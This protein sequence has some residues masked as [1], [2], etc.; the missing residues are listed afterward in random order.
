[1]APLRE[2]RLALPLHDLPAQPS[3]M[4]A[5]AAP[6]LLPPK[7]S[8]SAYNSFVAC[9][10]QFF[11]L[12]MLRVSVMDEL[13]DMPEKRD[14]GGWLHA[15]LMTYHET[16]RDQKT[17]LEQRTGLLARI[18]EQVFGA[19]IA[20]HPAALGYAAR[21]Q[22]VMPAYLLWANERETQGWYFA[23]GEAPMQQ[24]LAWPGG[25][26]ELHGRL[27]RIDESSVGERAVLDYKTRPLPSLV[28][29]L[30]DA[31]DHQ[32][33][34]YG[35]LS[36]QQLTAAHYV[37]LETFKDKTGDVAAPDFERRQHDLQQQIVTV[38]QAVQ[39]GAPLPANG[40]ESVCQYCEVRG[41]CRKG[42]WQ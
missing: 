16:V 12:R 23:A 19:A 27:D 10:Y 8:A 31:E 36:G 4:P 24:S 34:F 39:Q 18:S 26:I 5:P 6:D 30:K 22:K 9:P 17:A 41:L 32:L 29:K 20:Q 40:I 38:M 25:G 33:P 3:V 13:S 11:A 42:V 1:M 37:A 15:I 7:L 14:Y 2:V 35:L 28:T 21:W